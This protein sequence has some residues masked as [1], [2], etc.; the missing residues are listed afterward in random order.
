[1]PNH[2]THKLTC[3]GDPVVL[4]EMIKAIS[5]APGTLGEDDPGAV[6]DFERV[7]PSPPFLFGESLST[8]DQ[9]R[10]PNRN[11]YDWNRA[12]WGTKW[13]GYR[14]SLESVAGGSEVVIRF[15]TAW[16]VPEP[17]LAELSFLFP[18]LTFKAE[19]IDEGW[20]FAG[21]QHYQQGRKIGQDAVACDRGDPTFV[22]LYESVYGDAPPSDED[23]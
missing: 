6:L 20:N 2:V 22:N 23:E 10:H 3:T 15:Q 5:R 8:A 13:N 17:V 19:F 11:W 21:V 18:E 7:I 1:M 4:D 12:R 9:A 14:G 16:S